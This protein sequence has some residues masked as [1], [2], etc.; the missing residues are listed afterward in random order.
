MNAFLASGAV[1]TTTT[2]VKNL[3][4]II[5]G[6]FFVYNGSS[7]TIDPVDTAFDGIGNL[8]DIFENAKDIR[9]VRSAEIE[10]DSIHTAIIYIGGDGKFRILQWRDN[11]DGF[12]DQTSY[13]A[14]AFNG[15]NVKTEAFDYKGN[16]LSAATS[17]FCTVS[18][19]K[20]GE[21]YKV[22][23]WVPKATYSDIPSVSTNYPGRCSVT[24][25]T[26][27]T[28]L[29]TIAYPWTTYSSAKNELSLAWMP[30]GTN[31]IKTM[32]I[33]NASSSNWVFA[34]RF[35]YISKSA[36]SFNR[37]MIFYDDNEYLKLAVCRDHKKCSAN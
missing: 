8:N 28:S 14:P 6:D 27:A 20:N 29:I 21:D 18:E 15:L 3:S 34:A 2:G 30:K 12:T 35:N 1:L 11:V 33:D 36:D 23:M 31:D 10:S 16:E 19:S 25:Y 37:I 5:N 26:E 24:N 17:H 32:L 7:G 4:S 22:H 9:V 13:F